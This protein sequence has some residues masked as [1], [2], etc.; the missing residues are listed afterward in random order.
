MASFNGVLWDLAFSEAKEQFEISCLFRQQIEGIRAFFETPS[1]VFVTLPMGSGKSLIYQCLPFVADCLHG[2]PRCTST[3]VV[4]SPLQ[5]LM[6]DQVDRLQI[7]VFLLSQDTQWASQMA[8]FPYFF[9]EL[10]FLS[11]ALLNSDLHKKH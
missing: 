8:N 5:A 7:L 4:I 11:F 1:N 9:L 2:R 3:L 6:K 10:N